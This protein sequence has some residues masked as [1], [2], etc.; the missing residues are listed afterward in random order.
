[1][2]GTH[3]KAMIGIVKDGNLLKMSRVYLFMKLEF[4]RMSLNG[5]EV[6]FSVIAHCSMGFRI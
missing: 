2:C 4:V 6:E 3:L 1:M 5:T